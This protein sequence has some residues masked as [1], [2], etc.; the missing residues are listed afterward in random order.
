[1]LSS[2]RAERK[3]Q[4]FARPVHH[5]SGSGHG[6]A[7]TTRRRVLGAAA[8]LP[9]LALPTP[10]IARTP[11]ES[12][13]TRQSGTAADRTLW[14]DRL[15]RYRRLA[16]RAQAAAETGWFRAANDRFY[17]ESAD[18]NADQ[19][20]AFARLDR[21]EDFYWYRC[22]APLHRAA[23]TVVLTPAP[24][25]AALRTKLTVIRTH[26]LHEPGPMERDCLIV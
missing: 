25:L 11:V 19:E 7:G 14:N 21:A 24:D 9:A 10:V 3:R 5:T 13:G 18:P 23:A 8:A 26:Q 4:T 6:Q 15:A 12:R 16:A 2:V 22:I 1:M 20:A 17:R